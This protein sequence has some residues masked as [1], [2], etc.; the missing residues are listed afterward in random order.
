MAA[1]VQFFISGH[2]NQFGFGNRAGVKISQHLNTYILWITDITA[3]EFFSAVISKSRRFRNLIWLRQPCRKIYKRT[4]IEPRL[5]SVGYIFHY[6]VPKCIH[7]YWPGE[8]I[9]IHEML[10]VLREGCHFRQLIANK[11]AKYSIKNIYGNWYFAC[12]NILHPGFRS[13]RWKASQWPVSI[14]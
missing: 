11:P 7:K 2:T 4:S 3:P 10:K 6:F 5:A 9:T 1:A 14:W 8:Y 13:M 12:K